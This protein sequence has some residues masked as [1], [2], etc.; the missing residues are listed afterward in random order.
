VFRDSTVTAGHKIFE[1]LQLTLQLGDT[2]MGTHETHSNN[3][4]PICQQSGTGQEV[5][6]LVHLCCTLK[7]NV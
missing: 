7:E 1:V 4:W 6:L 2:L 5:L 3:F